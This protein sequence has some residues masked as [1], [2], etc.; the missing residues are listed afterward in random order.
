MTGPLRQ[1][2]GRRIDVSGVLESFFG[3]LPEHPAG[4]GGGLGHSRRRG[5]RAGGLGGPPAAGGWGG[6]RGGRRRA[7][8]RG[9]GRG[10]GRRGWRGP[11]VWRGRV[12]PGGRGASPCPFWGHCT[13]G[14]ACGSPPGRGRPRRRRGPRRR[15]RRGSTASRAERTPAANS[16]STC[17]RPESC[18]RRRWTACSRTC[19]SR[20]PRT[21]WTT[22]WRMAART[23][24][25]FFGVVV[26][27]GSDGVGEQEEVLGL[28]DGEGRGRPLRA[29]SATS[30]SCLRSRST[31]PRATTWWRCAGAPRSA[32]TSFWTSSPPPAGTT[33]RSGVDV[34]VERDVDA[35]GRPF[36][37]QDGLADAE[38]FEHERFRDPVG[39]PK[40]VPPPPLGEAV[41][42]LGVGEE[43]VN[44][45][46]PP[47]AAEPERR[48]ARPASGEV[49]VVGEVDE[50]AV[51]TGG[52]ELVPERADE[53]PVEE[54]LG[55]VDDDDG[56]GGPPAG[57]GGR[58]RARPARRRSSRPRGRG[59]GSRPVRP[60]VP[61]RRRRLSRTGRSGGRRGGPRWHG[62]GRTWWAAAGRRGAPSRALL[63]WA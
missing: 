2:L 21:R 6:R 27:E 25:G 33:W 39:R 42:G 60:R 61:L 36:Y 20:A 19:T 26:G 34:A 1:G 56:V 57:R 32:E 12:G 51:G 29:R 58:G 43:A 55:L 50:E 24:S 5:G 41:V 7:A 8:C 18:W 15:W 38:E 49:E 44:V 59:P 53:G 35:P 10:G 3:A 62:H 9:P 63:S 23:A 37:E 47:V 46:V 45:G 14:G 17:S 22:C 11:S 13:A 54:G 30:S 52:L 31:R 40:A 16:P 28:G 4:V 48:G